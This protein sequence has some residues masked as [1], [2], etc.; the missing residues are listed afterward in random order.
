MGNVLLE[1][2]TVEGTTI[3]TDRERERDMYFYLWK[4]CQL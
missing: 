4:S 1:T 3:E 2:P